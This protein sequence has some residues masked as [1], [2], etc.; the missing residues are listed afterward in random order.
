[1]LLL[2]LIFCTSISSSTRPAW[3]LQA[4]ELLSGSCHLF[5]RGFSLSHQTSSP[6]ILTSRATRKSPGNTL[7]FKYFDKKSI[8]RD[9]KR[10]WAS[11]RER[12]NC[13]IMV[14]VQEPEIN[15][16][17]RTWR[18]R[19]IMQNIKREDRLNHENNFVANELCCLTAS[20][21]CV[22]LKSNCCSR[23]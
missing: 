20:T 10:K 14:C 5:L 4:K 21:L 23:C 18:K 22:C 7:H 17:D 9:R 13:E 11:W 2:C 3:I 19:K 15:V 1:M 6:H 8:P 16:L 12:R